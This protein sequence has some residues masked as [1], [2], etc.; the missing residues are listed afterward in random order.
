MRKWIVNETKEPVS[1]AFRRGHLLPYSQ[2]VPFLKDHGFD[3]RLFFEQLFANPFPAFLGLDLIVWS[4]VLWTLV[5]VGG[6]RAGMKHLWAPLAANL[7][8]GVQGRL[9]GRA[10]SIRL[11]RPRAGIVG[12]DM[13]CNDVP[14]PLGNLPVPGGLA[15]QP[16]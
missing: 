9:L 10:G 16:G 3:L 15:S 12:L 11:G 14:A 5:V 4:V 7:A 2:L 6:R 8:V 13:E 1:A